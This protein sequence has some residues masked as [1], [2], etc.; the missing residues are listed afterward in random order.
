MGLSDFTNFDSYLEDTNIIDISNKQI[1]ALAQSLSKDCDTD[2][3]IAKSCFEF[4]RDKI[5]HTADIKAKNTTTYKASEVL[6][7]QNGW[8]YAKSHLLAALLRANKIPTGFCYQYLSCG[9]YKDEIY[10]LHGLNAIYLKEYGWYKIDPRGNK[11]GVDAQF[12]PP[13]EKLAFKLE[14]DEYDLA[15]I[16]SKPLDIVV[17]SLQKNSTLDLMLNNLPLTNEYIRRVKIEDALE[18]SEL[19]ISLLDYLFEEIPSWFKEDVNKQ[20]F[21]KRILDSN[22]LHHIYVKDKKIVGL[23]TIKDKNHLFHLFVDSSYHKK[24]IAKKLFESIKSNMDVN[25]MNVNAS[26]YA[27]PMYKALGFKKCGEKNRYKELEY[28]PMV[29]KG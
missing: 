26:I 18:L 7:Y 24:G 22:Y 20:S 15:P 4:V 10:C 19:V 25:G 16:Y 27:I 3:Q 12:T 6:K 17:K 5:S 23:I 9:E 11:Q 28:Q 8:C 13:Y 1:K 29:Y 21:E 2:E 14:K